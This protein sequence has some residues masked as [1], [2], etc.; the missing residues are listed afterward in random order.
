MHPIERLRQGPGP[1]HVAHRVLVGE[2]GPALARLGGDHGALVLS[3]RR[4]VAHHP[5]SGPLAWLCARVLCGHDARADAWG[6]IT[7]MDDDPTAQ[8]L[9]ADLPDD[10]TVVVLGWPE[11]AAGALAGRGDVTALV[12]D[13]GGE[14]AELALRLRAIDGDATDVAEAGTAAAVVAADLVVLE[15]DALGPD[16]A[17]AASGS[18]AAAAV[19][20][21][22]GV[23]VWLVAGTGRYLPAGMWSGL[24]D[25]LARPEPWAAATEVVPLGLVDA[26]VRPGG[27]SVPAG[28]AGP[29]DCPE[30][31]EL[32]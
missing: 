14:G 21:H 5:S 3:C 23:P 17:V 13:A 4:L 11:V 1:G 25:R 6:C 12:I 30:A 15:A 7:E 19:A 2:S 26:V 24:V 20:R 9:V 22:A 27:R 28:P 16:G 32:R 29:A 18:Y 8:H 31:P 10:A